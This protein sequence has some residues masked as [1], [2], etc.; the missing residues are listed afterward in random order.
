MAITTIK[1]IY[2]S[3]F[4]YR[5]SINEIMYDETD[6]IALTARQEGVDDYGSQEDIR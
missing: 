1:M 3:Y 4:E 5:T 6:I 2:E